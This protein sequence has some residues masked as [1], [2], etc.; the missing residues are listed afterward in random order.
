M[1]LAPATRLGAYEIVSLIGT[2]G[3]GEVYKAVDTRLGR[4]VAIKVSSEQFSERFE[5]EARAVAALNHPHICQLYD[6][7]P[8]YLVMEYVEGAPIGPA[9]DPQRLIELANQAADA[10]VAAHRAGIV[11]RDL[12]P[13][14]IL[15]TRDGQV[16]VLDF[17]IATIA[18]EA[19]GGADAA[20]TRAATEPGVTVGTV[21]YMSPEQ[22]RGQMVDART[23][24]WSLGVVL[25]EIA[26]GARPFEGPT[27]PVVFEAILGK[28]PAA[29]RERNLKVPEGL[30]RIIDRLLEKD[31][32]TRYQS[33]ADLRADLKRLG[34]T[35]GVTAVAPTPVHAGTL[36]LKYGTAA[37]VLLLAAA[38]FFLRPRTEAPLQTDQDLLILAEFTNNTGDPVFDRTLRDALAVQLEQSPLLKVL[39]DEQV[40][41]DLRLIGR[42]PDDRVTDQVARDICLREAQKATIGGAIASLGTTYAITLQATNCQTGEPIAREQVEAAGKEQVLDAIARAARGMREKLG[43]SLVTIATPR[44]SVNLQVTTTSLEAFQAYS[45]GLEQWYQGAYIDAIPFFQ[46]AT[47]LDS[48]FASAW[49]LLGIT[50]ATVRAGEGQQRD[51][52]TRAFGL[53]DRVSEKERLAISAWYYFSVTRETTKARDGLQAWIRS[54]P[55]DAEP[56]VTLGNLLNSLG[57]WE[58]AL[59]EYLA[60]YRLE[61]WV[62]VVS[63][64]LMLQYARLNRIDE[65]LAV[66][67]DVFARKFDPPSIHQALLGI[68]LRKGDDAAVG[69]EIRWFTGNPEEWQIYAQRAQDAAIHGQGRHARELALRAVELARQ[70]NLAQAVGQLQGLAAS[71]GTSFAD[72]PM[73]RDI[74]AVAALACRDV[75]GDV[76]NAEEA[77]Q[78]FPDAI[79][80]NAIQL[81]RLRA[82]AALQRGEANQALELLR[83][84]EPYDRADPLVPYLRGLAYLKTGHGAE[85]AA[86]FQALLDRAAWDTPYVLAH[87][88]AGRGHT[89]AG[90]A[91]RARK[92]YDD[93]FVLWAKADPEIPVLVAARKEYAALR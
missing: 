38:A 73:V 79:P 64:N 19:A 60:A 13:D 92:A 54:Y 70:R 48:G 30:A 45:R 52:L 10:L 88:G 66:S 39:G 41:H 15:V 93:F 84:V 76:G 90:D 8:N 37:A 81:P 27:A 9:E 61:P 65:A 28:E 29:V 87:L 11:H 3:M 67:K 40:R 23:D 49:R 91:A 7:G 35:S 69:E 47:E 25:Y 2:G 6:V 46:R 4:T 16:K 72:C 71:V 89:L 22:A 53:V 80:L 59:D 74:G 26:T 5:R 82:A 43:E 20:L 34:R 36:W 31:R 58:G 75:T 68:A 21:A 14:N 77:A 33:A 83:A 18:H 63:G 56:R 57:E 44:E 51:A 85:A 32:D 86:A 24:L 50:Y 42:S 17:G 12:K 78:R 62:S 55:R 1:P